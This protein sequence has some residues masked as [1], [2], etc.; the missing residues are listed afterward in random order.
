MFHLTEAFVLLKGVQ[1][2]T[3]AVFLLLFGLPP[4]DRMPVDTAAVDNFSPP[5]F[6]AHYVLGDTRGIKRH[7]YQAE[8]DEQAVAARPNLSSCLRPHPDGTY[9]LTAIDW[10]GFK[11]REEIE[12]CL[13]YIAEFLGSPESFA[14]WL[15]ALRFPEVRVTEVELSMACR[16][17]HGI[18]VSGRIFE[19]SRFFR[20]N[21]RLFA[22]VAIAY[23]LRFTVEYVKGDIRRIRV[24]WPF[25]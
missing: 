20:M 1:T 19:K 22:N 23:Q 10:P 17:C 13:Y 4:V 11:S 18:R 7:G 3:T 15:N 25:K 21:P 12:V 2:A 9:S 8:Y 14:S 5:S 24:D 16:G 6:P